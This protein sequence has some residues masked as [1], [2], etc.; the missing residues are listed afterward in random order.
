MQSPISRL[1][2][3]YEFVRTVRE[4]VQIQLSLNS[5]LYGELIL[6][7]QYDNYRSGKRLPWVK[8]VGPAGIE[9]ATSRL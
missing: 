2:A 9:P 4:S 3:L 7:H 1:Y 8:E 6:L 5:K